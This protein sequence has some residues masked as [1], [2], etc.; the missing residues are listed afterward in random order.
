MTKNNIHFYIV[1]D[2]NDSFLI[3]LLCC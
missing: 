2:L 1:S 3:M